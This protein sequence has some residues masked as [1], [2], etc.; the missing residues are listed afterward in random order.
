MVSIPK[1]YVVA[2]EGTPFAIDAW[3]KPEIKTVYD[4]IISE[5]PDSDKEEWKQKLSFPE[6]TLENG[7]NKRLTD[8]NNLKLTK[9]K[10]AIA[11]I[12]LSKV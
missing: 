5:M 7:V 6:L 4:E 8:F 9:T 2:P 10:S 12:E 3:R 1:R 11:Q